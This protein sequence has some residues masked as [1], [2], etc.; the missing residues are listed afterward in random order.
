LNSLNLGTWFDKLK[1]LLD[2]I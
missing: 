2:W 1:K